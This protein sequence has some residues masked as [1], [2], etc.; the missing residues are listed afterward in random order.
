MK[1]VRFQVV[2]KTKG[3]STET[4]TFAASLLKGPA[5]NG[6]CLVCVLR[7][8]CAEEA[9]NEAGFSRVVFT[10][11]LEKNSFVCGLF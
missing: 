9:S 1:R 4:W 2:L 8:L 10:R 5:S 7:S 6:T 3:S 11:V